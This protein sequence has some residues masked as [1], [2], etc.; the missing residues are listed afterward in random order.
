MEFYFTEKMFISPLSEINNT[1]IINAKCFDISMSLYNLIE[2]SDNYAKL[3]G[4]LWQY[5][6]NE[7]ADDIT[8]PKTFKFKL[9]FIDK[10]NDNR[11]VNIKIVVPLKYLLR[12]WRALEIF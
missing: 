9:G 2:Y 10:T 3:S 5:Y 6:R 11:N 12:L 1:Q 7:P 4:R 8:G